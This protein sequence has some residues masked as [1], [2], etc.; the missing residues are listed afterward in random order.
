MSPHVTPC[1]RVLANRLLGFRGERR[2]VT[3][4][5][6]RASPRP[7]VLPHRGHPAVR[8][9][10][11]LSALT[12]R[13]LGS[14]PKIRPGFLTFVAR[15]TSVPEPLGEDGTLAQG[16]EASLP[17]KRPLSG[18][19]LP[20]PHARHLHTLPGTPAR[21]SFPPLHA[22]VPDAGLPV[23]R[24]FG[25]ALLRPPLRAQGVENIP[26]DLLRFRLYPPSPALL[27]KPLSASAAGSLGRPSNHY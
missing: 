23:S 24:P 18:P 8:L 7:G 4:G 11:Y 14:A 15:G 17:L 9:P 12:R 25:H 3:Q 21:P 5:P 16:E 13:R 6:V 26:E 2:G 22:R 27:V 20:C 1:L 10:A 19:G